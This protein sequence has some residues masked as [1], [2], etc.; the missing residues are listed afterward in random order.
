[1]VKSRALR[2]LRSGDFIRVPVV[3]RVADPWLTEVVGRLG[4]DAIWLD[5]EHRPLGYDILNPI[6]LACRATGIDLIVRILKTGYSTPMRVLESGA[7]GSMVP[8]CRS[9]EEARQWVE[10]TRF[11]PLGRRGFDGAGV[12]ADYMLA[13][14]LEYLDHA[15]RETLLI[16]QVE[17][18]EA[19]E[20]VEKI[21]AVEGVDLLLIGPADLTLS[22]GVPMQLEHPEVQKAIDRVASAV[23]KAGKWWGIATA[24]PQAAQRALDR[25]ARM[26]TCGSDHVFLVR[27]FQDAYVQFKDLSIP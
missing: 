16:L 7:N 25:G 27:G 1:M 18:W 12:D 20:C 9:V 26:I 8:H 24:T 22:Y 17:D 3:S 14:P 13:D 5:M 23:A 2:K 15:N 21:A 6:S 4:F 10:W 11:L 19:V